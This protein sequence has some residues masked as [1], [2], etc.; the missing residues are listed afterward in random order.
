MKHKVCLSCAPVMFHIHNK[1]DLVL[2]SKGKCGCSEQRNISK[3][4]RE[5]HNKNSYKWRKEYLDLLEKQ[6]QEK[7][8][9]SKV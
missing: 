9:E 6:E 2:I 5:Y 4:E 7:E 8:N 1:D 3:E